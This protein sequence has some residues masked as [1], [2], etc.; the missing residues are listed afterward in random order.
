[1]SEPEYTAEQ[2]AEMRRNSYQTRCQGKEPFA[3]RAMAQQVARRYGNAAYKC[4][5]C[6]KWHVGG[7]AWVPPK[8][9]GQK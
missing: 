5:N 4:A 9:R 2:I 8:R 3:S 6:R 7:R 1:M